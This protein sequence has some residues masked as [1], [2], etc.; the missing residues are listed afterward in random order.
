MRKDIPSTS[1]PFSFRRY[2][3]TDESTPP[4]IPAITFGI[5]KTITD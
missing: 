5:R 1:Y 2:A 4:L 3:A